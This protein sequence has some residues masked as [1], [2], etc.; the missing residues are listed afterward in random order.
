VQFFKIARGR[1]K[2]NIFGTFKGQMDVLGLEGLE[3]NYRKFKGL[4]QKGKNIRGKLMGA[5]VQ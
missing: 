4:L 5:K 3:R 2:R 1:P